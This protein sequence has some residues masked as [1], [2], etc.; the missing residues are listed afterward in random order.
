MIGESLR[1]R[2]PAAVLA[3]GLGSYLLTGCSGMGNPD[4]CSPTDMSRKCIQQSAASKIVFSQLPTELQTV[5]KASIKER[6][7]TCLTKDDQLVD[8]DQ[9]IVDPKVK[10]API[11][12]AVITI[13]CNGG[14][15]G[16]FVKYD[17]ESPWKLAET[18]QDVFSCNEVFANP[19]PEQLLALDHA[20]A[21][22]TNAF[23]Q[24]IPYVIA[25]PS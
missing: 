25:A 22:C 14:P 20:T 21:E 17:S 10:Y 6:A 15:D 16:L 5:A 7:P 12:S 13:G 3:A 24:Q 2:V 19:V 4:I 11:G 9:R 8:A 23:G 18:T 1:M